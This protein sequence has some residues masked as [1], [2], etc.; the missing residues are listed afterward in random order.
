MGLKEPAP[1]YPDAWQNTAL[2]KELDVDLLSVF[3]GLW[4]EWD[5]IHVLETR[6]FVDAQEAQQLEDMLCGGGDPEEILKPHV[7]DAYR[8]RRRSA[9]R[10]ACS[11]KDLH[12]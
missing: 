3:F 8:R 9:I 12:R 11:N 7:V 4:D 6:G 10:L 5:A 2:G 1:G